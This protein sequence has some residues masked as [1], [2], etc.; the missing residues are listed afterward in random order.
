MC[1][2]DLMLPFAVQI[3]DFVQVV[4]ARLWLGIAPWHG[5]RRHLTH[6]VQNQGLRPVLVAPLFF[7]LALGCGLS[8]RWMVH[9][10]VS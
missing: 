2:S 10:G 1:S 8:A 3:I 9:R 4:T 6:I 5:D 7:L